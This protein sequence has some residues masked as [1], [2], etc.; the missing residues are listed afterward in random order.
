[1]ITTE[2]E[3]HRALARIAELMDSEEGTPEGQELERL[4]VAVEKYERVTYPIPAPDDPDI[5]E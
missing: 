5:Y 4:A 1:M 3:Y 2:E